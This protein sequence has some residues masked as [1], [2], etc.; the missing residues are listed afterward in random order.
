MLKK[1]AIVL[2]VFLASAAL[3]AT[4][5]FG[6]EP[7]SSVVPLAAEPAC[8][9]TGCASTECHDYANVP[10]PD[11]IHAMNCPK[12][13]CSSTDCHAWDT[14]ISGYRQASDASLNLWVLAPVALCVV[15]VA[16]VRASSR[17]AKVGK[18][19]KGGSDG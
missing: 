11:G 4:V 8:P 9:A 16:V 7:K 2:V 19:G 1:I 12:A 6:S 18:V 3:V 10:Y 17:G 13:S 14:L 15:L 5:G